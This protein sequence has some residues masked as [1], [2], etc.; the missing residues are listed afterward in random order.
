[1]KLFSCSLILK[2]IWML[3]DEVY[4]LMQNISKAPSPREEQLQ[5][6]INLS[7]SGSRHSRFAVEEG[8]KHHL[9]EYL[10]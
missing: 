9:R 8:Q 7:I 1:M 3:C 2:Q 10:K 6:A 5:E 4:F